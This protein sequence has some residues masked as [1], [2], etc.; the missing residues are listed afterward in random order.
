MNATNCTARWPST[1]AAPHSFPCVTRK[2]EEGPCATPRDCSVFRDWSSA[3]RPP[4]RGK[5]RTPPSPPDLPS[6]SERSLSRRPAAAAADC[7]RPDQ[8]AISPGRVCAPETA[9][10]A[11]TAAPPAPTPTPR[12]RPSPPSSSEVLDLGCGVRLRLA[13]L[14]RLSAPYAL[15]RPAPPRALTRKRL[16]R[17]PQSIELLREER[18]TLRSPAPQ[19]SATPASAYPRGLPCHSWS[20]F[21]LATSCTDL[22]H[23]FDF[24]REQALTHS[25]NPGHALEDNPPHCAF[26]R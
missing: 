2:M 25:F 21:S 1:S 12:A 13:H 14:S 8:P 10:L 11:P 3:R 20:K 6:T 16:R 5:S 22:R 19:S 7:T 23:T 18:V 24:L 26:A 17:P 15:P 9:D 4:T